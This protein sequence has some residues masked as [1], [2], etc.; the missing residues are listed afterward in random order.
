MRYAIF[1]VGESNQ[2]PCHPQIEHKIGVIL[3][4][5]S[6]RHLPLDGLIGSDGM[7]ESSEGDGVV[8]V[9]GRVS[10]LAMRL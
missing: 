2:V 8:V 9:V 10:D 1:T 6:E 3:R 4:N 7:I 5:A